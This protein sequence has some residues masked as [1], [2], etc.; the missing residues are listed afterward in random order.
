M[1]SAAPSHSDSSR[2]EERG[3]TEIVGFVLSFSIIIV[4]VGLLMTAGFGSLNDLQGNQQVNNAEQVFIA[5]SDGFADLEEGYAPSRTGLVELQG[6]AFLR[7]SNDSEIDVTVNGPG[8]SD[9]IRTRSLEYRFKGITVAYENG[10]VFR[11]RN[12]NSV[13][14]GS[15]PGFYC[16]NSSNV[17]IISLVTIEAPSEPSISGGTVSIAATQQSTKLLYPEDRTVSTVQN[18]TVE[19]DSPHADAWDR[20][21]ADEDTDWVEK[22]KTGRASCEDVSEVFVRHSVIEIRFVS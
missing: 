20:H 15:S 2:S 16:S 11:E 21:F 12:N 17:A 19:V 3:V 18:V 10:A 1:N 7:V 13:M 9:T 6:E 22:S 8:F 4:S 14:T 5:M